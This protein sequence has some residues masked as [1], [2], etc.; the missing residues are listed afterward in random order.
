MKEKKNF[1]TEEI[2]LR[3]A[4]LNINLFTYDKVQ[5]DVINFMLP[6]I[7]KYAAKFSA[8]GT[9]LLTFDDYVN[10]GVL[11]VHEKIPNFKFSKNT[12]FA[13]YFTWHIIDAMQC[14]KTSMEQAY[15]TPTT[16]V[17]YEKKI[18]TF[19]KA[20]P[21]V[22]MEE[23]ANHFKMSLERVISIIDSGKRSTSVFQT[24][25]GISDDS[26]AILDT[27]V[28]NDLNGEE[29]AILKNEQL[30]VRKNLKAALD[31][32]EYE[33]LSRNFGLG[34]NDFE[35]LE[36][37]SRDLNVSRERVRQIKNEALEKIRKSE[38][39]SEIM[40][41]LISIVQIQSSQK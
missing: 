36:K 33:V 2:K 40:S 37:I 18:T 30:E 17:K 31:D 27:F 7:K 22:S 15:K 39:A 9:G 12:K 11:R 16:S 3:E 32:R 8:N 10:E 35:T 23:V 5:E 38:K 1:D 25:S 29:E 21:D 28:S 20:N 24:V 4:V 6:L 41:S 34:D 19:I 14:L 26:K 13:T